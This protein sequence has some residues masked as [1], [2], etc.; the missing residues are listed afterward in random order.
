MT[1]GTFGGHPGAGRLTMTV[2]VM[3]P[4]TTK[5]QGRLVPRHC[6]IGLSLI[7][8]EA[9]SLYDCCISRALFD[10]N[11]GCFSRAERGVMSG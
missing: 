8:I 6:E 3:G 5:V 9:A 2:K 11:A 4:S 1:A 10:V 7:D